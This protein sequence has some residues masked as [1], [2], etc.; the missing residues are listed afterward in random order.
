MS[1]SDDLKKERRA[2]QEKIKKYEKR[3][4]QVE[5][6]LGNVK[7]DFE[8]E[9]NGLNR[10]LEDIAEQQENGFI[11][12]SH[13]SL[14]STKLKGQKEKSTYSDKYMADVQEELGNDI[15]DTNNKIK[16]AEQNITR[17]NTEIS[18]AEREEEEE[19]KKAMEE[20][21]AKMFGKN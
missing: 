10:K 5:K 12:F 7:G 20:V 15:R 13:I 21:L 9:I 18:Q 6:I 14:V 4:S 11:R 1:R 8:G 16:E 19:R 2:E 3:K 17:L